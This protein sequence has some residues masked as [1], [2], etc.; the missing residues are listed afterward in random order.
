MTTLVTTHILRPPLGS[1]EQT[2]EKASAEAPTIPL[3]VIQ[4]FPYRPYSPTEFEYTRSEDRER[5]ISALLARP[6]DLTNLRES[7]SVLNKIAISGPLSPGALCALQGWIRSMQK[8]LNDDQVEEERAFSDSPELLPTVTE[9]REL[10]QNMKKT[11]GL[12]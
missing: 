5:G 3:P 6:Q 10:F 1:R 4:L 7:S 12:S 11:I 9:V 2:V 8:R